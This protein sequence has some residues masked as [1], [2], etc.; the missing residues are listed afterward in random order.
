MAGARKKRLLTRLIQGQK[1]VG[2]MGAESGAKR[3]LEN[4]EKEGR[5]ALRGAPLAA[6]R[7]LTGVGDDLGGFLYGRIHLSRVGLNE[8]FQYV[9]GGRCR[10]VGIVE[11][12]IEL[13]SFHGGIAASLLLTFQLYARGAWNST[14]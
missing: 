9:V 7:F 3:N 11:P 4:R 6:A 8:D 10:G 12:V 5:S 13:A 14:R 1:A 2:C